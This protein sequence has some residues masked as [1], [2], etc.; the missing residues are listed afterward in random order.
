MA[1]ILHIPTVNKRLILRIMINPLYSSASVTAVRTVSGPTN[2]RNLQGANNPFL[3]A[4]VCVCVCVCVLVCACVRVSV[5][6]LQGT[7]PQVNCQTSAHK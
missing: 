1:K 5:C 2:I 3:L 6:V 4:R 7:G